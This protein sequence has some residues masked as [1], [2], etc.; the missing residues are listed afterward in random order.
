MISILISSILRPLLRYWVRKAAPLKHGTILLPGLDEKVGV[1]WDP[2]AIPHLCAANEH[3]LFMTQGYLHAQERLWQMDINR[4]FLSGRLAEVLGKSP[5]PW[6]ELSIRFQE[7]TTVDLDFFIRLMGIRRAACASLK[8]LPEP[9][10][11][12]L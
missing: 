11:N 10:V 5:V 1:S 9:L 8:L 12:H 6:R 4:R 7:R 3:D 2:Y